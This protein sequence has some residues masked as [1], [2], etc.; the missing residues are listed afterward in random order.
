MKNGAQKKRLLGYCVAAALCW[1]MAG[2]HACGCFLSELMAK[3]PV[4]RSVWDSNSLQLKGNYFCSR[5][6]NGAIASTAA[7]VVHPA[8]ASLLQLMVIADRERD[9]WNGNKK[10]KSRRG[11][12]RSAG[13][14]HMSWPSV[15]F[16]HKGRRT[17]ELL[18]HLPPSECVEIFQVYSVISCHR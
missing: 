9:D 1:S 8:V 7:A 17:A 10:A 12:E 3:Q 15:I 14:R 4:F 2:K 11:S 5:C 18:P 13:C 6:G 16:S